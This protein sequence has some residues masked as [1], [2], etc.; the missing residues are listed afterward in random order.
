MNRENNKLRAE[1]TARIN[2]NTLSPTMASVS[3]II[4]YGNGYPKKWD[5]VIQKRKLV[6][7]IL[8][9]RRT[10][11]FG[12]FLFCHVPVNHQGI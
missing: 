11:L 9:G 12:R 4:Y 5:G 7:W 6:N 8:L 3:I 2:N 1:F 10:P